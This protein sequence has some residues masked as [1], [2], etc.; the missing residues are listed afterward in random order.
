MIIGLTGNKGVGKDTAGA[1]L[2]QHCGFERAAFADKLKEAVAAL[3]D[4]PLEWVDE[5]K[6]NHGK[7]LDAVEVIVDNKGLMQY[8]FGW[9]EFLQRF[10]TEMGR[11]IF[12]EWFWVD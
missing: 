5:F 10:G 11:N 4:F 1:F 7:S 3:F 8:S 6:D 9:R 2:V 12:G